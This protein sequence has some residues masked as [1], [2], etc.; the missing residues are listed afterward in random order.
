MN[1]LID[2]HYDEDYVFGL[3]KK[4]NGFQIAFGVTAYDSNQEMIDDPDYV[5]LHA[6]LK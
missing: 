1:N 2:S 4:D 5:T 6:R 3:D